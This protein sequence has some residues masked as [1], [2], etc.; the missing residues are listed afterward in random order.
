MVK[1]DTPNLK[2]NS[3]TTS[4]SDSMK[5][6]HL[7]LDAL[8]RSI[9]MLDSSAFYGKVANQVSGAQIILTDLRARVMEDLKS[10]VLQSQY[11]EAKPLD[12]ESPK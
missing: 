2:E 3:M 6:R 9:Y 12:D 10:L 5:E 4:V 1:L 7:D 11:L 8:N